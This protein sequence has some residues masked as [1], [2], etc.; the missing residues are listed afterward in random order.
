MRR[1]IGWGAAA[2]WLTHVKCVGHSDKASALAER[3]I[4][5][6][7]AAFDTRF[8]R[9]TGVVLLRDVHFDDRYL[10]TRVRAVELAGN[11]A[12]AADADLVSAGWPAGFVLTVLNGGCDALAIGGS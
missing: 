12:I 5:R 1:S 4:E 3:T 9:C 2:R 6:G 8:Q 10:L 11:F 7:G